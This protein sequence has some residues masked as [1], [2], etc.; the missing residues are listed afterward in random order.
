MQPVRVDPRV[1]LRL[2]P[3]TLFKRDLMTQ[4]CPACF[5]DCFGNQG[6]QEVLTFVSL[7]PSWREL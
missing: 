2:Y 1:G 4:A 5:G 6:L 7:M 3:W